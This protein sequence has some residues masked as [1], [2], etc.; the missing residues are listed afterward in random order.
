[1]NAKK[2]VVALSAIVLGLTSCGNGGA[3][4]TRKEAETKL[5]EIV[6]AT[7]ETQTKLTAQNKTVEPSEVVSTYV[8]DGA[9]N[10]SHVTFNK[11]KELKVNDASY[12]VS[13]LYAYLDGANYVFGFKGKVGDEANEVSYVVTLSSGSALVAGSMAGFAQNNINAFVECGRKHWHNG[14]AG[15][16]AYLK[17]QDTIEA[18]GYENRS[19]IVVGD[20]TITTGATDKGSYIKLADEKYTSTGAGNLTLDFDALYPNPS[21]PEKLHEP[22]LFEF[23]NNLLTHWYNKKASSY[24]GNEWVMNYGFADAAKATFA[25]AGVSD[26][27]AAAYATAITGLISASVQADQPH[28]VSDLYPA[29][30]N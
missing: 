9:N 6:A 26:L 12:A 25:D 30:W 24:K 4:L 8:F 23:N 19:D 3:S 18:E 28:G 17:R 2:L 14:A 5:D 13:E 16:S 27:E 29:H 20:Q 1:M 15:L 7:P 21:A 11:A 22:L 10:Y